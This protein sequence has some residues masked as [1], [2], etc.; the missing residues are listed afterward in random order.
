MRWG[1]PNL[2]LQKKKTAVSYFNLGATQYMLKDY[3]SATEA[4]KWELNIRQKVLGEDHENTADSYHE[5]GVTQDVLR[6][7]TSATES[8]K[9]ALNIRQKVLGED[10]EKTTLSYFNLGATQLGE[11]RQKASSED[12][13]A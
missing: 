6:D 10:Y 2:C 13:E 9:R 7:Y 12:H 3:A 8:Q 5:Q 4:H 1:L 11:I